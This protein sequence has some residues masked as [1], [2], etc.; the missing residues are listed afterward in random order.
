M[1]GFYANY[2]IRVF[3]LAHV[4]QMRDKDRTGAGLASTTGDPPALPGRQQR[5]DRS[6]SMFLYSSAPA[7]SIAAWSL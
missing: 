6:R 1:S 5:F 2:P 7:I 4:R 3:G